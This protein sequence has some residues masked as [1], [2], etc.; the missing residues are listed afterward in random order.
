MAPFA[1]LGVTATRARTAE[2]A[3]EPENL[4][5]DHAGYLKL[6]DFGFAKRVPDGTL[7]HTL[8]GT[9]EYICPEVPH[10]RDDMA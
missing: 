3:L 2:H 10:A 4:L 9:P 8:V 7:T 6:V 1:T 5:L